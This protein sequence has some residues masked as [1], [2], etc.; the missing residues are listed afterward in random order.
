M[1]S[2]GQTEPSF[3][4]ALLK[5]AL[6]G[7][8]LLLMVF[9]FPVSFPPFTSSEL[10]LGQDMCVSFLFFFLFHLVSKLFAFIFWFLLLIG[11]T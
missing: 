7:F 9:I 11:L 6:P 10:S 4:R 2:E 5:E 3:T 8:L 1:N